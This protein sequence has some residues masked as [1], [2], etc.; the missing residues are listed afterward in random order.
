MYMERRF[1]LVFSARWVTRDTNTRV[2]LSG[3]EDTHEGE[4]SD[5]ITSIRTVLA[6]SQGPEGSGPLSL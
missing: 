5:S 6:I 4:L 2:D 1:D 3:C